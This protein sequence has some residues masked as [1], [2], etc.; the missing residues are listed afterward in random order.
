MMDFHDWAV[1]VTTIVRE[2]LPMV[3]GLRKSDSVVWKYGAKTATL[4]IQDH[5]WW[6]AINTG[7]GT[8]PPRTFDNRH[9]AESA[10]VAAANI[11]IHF[12]PRYCQGLDVEPYPVGSMK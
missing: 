3:T 8:P 11:V 5:S 10:R 4:T 9:D 6:M 2:Y 12:E 7:E 1:L